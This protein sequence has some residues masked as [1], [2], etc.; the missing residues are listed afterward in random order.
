M[1]LIAGVT[2]DLTDR[3]P[4]GELIRAITPIVDGKGGGKPDMAQ[5]GGTDASKID[6]ALNQVYHWVSERGGSE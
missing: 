4:A 5:G 6:A 2:K 1:T 3:F